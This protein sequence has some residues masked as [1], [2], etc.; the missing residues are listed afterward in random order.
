MAQG[1]RRRRRVH[2]VGRRARPGAARGARVRAADGHPGADGKRA[3]ADAGTLGHQLRLPEGQLVAWPWPTG[4]P[5]TAAHARP[6]GPDPGARRGRDDDQLSRSHGARHR[7]AVPDEGSGPDARRRWDWCSPR[8]R[9]ATRLLQI[10]GGIFL[11]RFGTRLTYFIAVGAA[12]RSSPALMGVVQL[13]RR[14][15]PDAHRRRRLRGAVL[16]RQQPHPGDVVPAAGARARQLD[17][18]GRA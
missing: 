1:L 9:G 18:L 7:G 11:D 6:L 13:A 5:S 8:S 14:A 10:P 2:P 15:D 16:S 4:A 12:G 3:D 17:L